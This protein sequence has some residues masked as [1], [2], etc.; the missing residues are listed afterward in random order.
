MR[1]GI[2][3]LLKTSVHSGVNSNSSEIIAICN[4]LNEIDGVYCEVIN[5]VKSEIK[6]NLFGSYNSLGF[7]SIYYKDANPDNYDFMLVMNSNPNFFGGVESEEIVGIYKFLHNFKNPIIYLYNDTNCALK[8]LRV[9]NNSTFTEDDV[10][11]DSPIYVVSQF[12]DVNKSISENSKNFNIKGGNIL[13]LALG[14]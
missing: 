2:C 3:N 13:I 10:S 11:I 6:R 9:R 7:N 5:K 14:C 1:I 4:Q 12:F 8:S